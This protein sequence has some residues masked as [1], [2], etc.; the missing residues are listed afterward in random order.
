MNY[1][2][3]ENME[4]PRSGRS[5]ANQ[6]RIYT[7]DGVYFQ[8]YARTI[9]FKPL[10]GKIVLDENYWDYSNTTTRYRN[11]FLR[12]NTKETRQKIEAGIYELAD[13]NG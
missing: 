7:N 10:Q 6:F 12:E 11:E 13:L 9:A 1:P 2:K 4:S 8:S 3:V 5:V